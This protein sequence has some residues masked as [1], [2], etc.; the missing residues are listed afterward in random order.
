MISKTNIHS[1]IE[2]KKRKKNKIHI[3]NFRCSFFS[4]HAHR[5]IFWLR[6]SY[7]KIYFHAFL[8][9]SVSVSGQEC[10]RGIV[11]HLNARLEIIPL[12]HFLVLRRGNF[13]PTAQLLLGIVQVKDRH[14]IQLALQYQTRQVLYVVLPA[15]KSTQNLVVPCTLL[16]HLPRSSL[17]CNVPGH[18][19]TNSGVT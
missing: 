2:L 3:H 9:N 1:N 18:D 4:I 19:R 6:K 13:S 14:R 16:L 5:C 7:V 10:R 12:G 17:S 8:V 11:S 15:G